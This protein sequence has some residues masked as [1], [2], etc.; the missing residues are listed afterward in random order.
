MVVATIQ[1]KNKETDQITALNGHLIYED[2][3]QKYI[4]QIIDIIDSKKINYRQKEEIRYAGDKFIAF[5]RHNQTD[6]IGRTRYAIMLY[7]KNTPKEEID[8]TLEI[9]GLNINNFEQ[10][11]KSYKKTQKLIK[12][13]YIVIAGVLILVAAKRF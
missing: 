3:E 13:I 8:K 9:M 2:E 7:D 6:D 10:I 12:G 11:L 1:G 4:N 5:L